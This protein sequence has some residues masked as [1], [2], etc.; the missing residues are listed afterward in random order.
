[1]NRKVCKFKKGDIWCIV[2]N[3]SWGAETDWAFIKLLVT[4]ACS[5]VP[6]KAYIQNSLKGEKRFWTE[7]YDRKIHKKICETC[8][9]RLK[10][11]RLKA[12]L[13]KKI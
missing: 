9:K 11:A 13:N 5:N 12:E 1:M 10:E 6:R 7:A 4:T 8:I 2:K 3:V